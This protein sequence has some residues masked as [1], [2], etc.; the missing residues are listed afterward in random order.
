MAIKKHVELSPRQ[1]KRCDLLLYRGVCDRTCS[2][3]H[4]YVQ[5]DV[6]PIAWAGSVKPMMLSVGNKFA[7]VVV[8]TAHPTTKNS[9]DVIHITKL[10]DFQIDQL[11]RGKG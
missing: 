5:F 1:C 4:R 10:S 9:V 7:P 8:G 11:V 2:T 6:N 3:L